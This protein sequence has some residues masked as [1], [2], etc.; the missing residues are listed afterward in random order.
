MSESNVCTL[1]PL[2]N[3]MG[4]RLA[5]S[6]IC[7]ILV[8]A[9]QVMGAGWTVGI[10]HPAGQTESQ[11]SAISGR[12][13]GYVAGPTNGGND[14]AAIF[15]SG[16]WTDL[17]PS[18]TTYSRA[19]GVSGDQVVGEVLPQ[20]GD[21]GVHAALWDAN[22]GSLTDLHPVGKWYSQAFGTD[23]IQQV[24]TAGS[25][26][27]LWTGSA[28]SIVYLTDTSIGSPTSV[29]YGVSGGRQVGSIWN[30]GTYRASLWSGSASS[31]VDLHP[32]GAASSDALA[33]SG[34]QQVG[35]SRTFAHDHAC[36]WRGSADSWTDLHPSG[37]YQSQASAVFGGRQAGWVQMEDYSLH[38]SIWAGSAG[39]WLDL[40]SYLPST[41]YESFAT[42][43]SV[44]GNDIWVAG[45]AT[46][47][48]TNKYEAVVWHQVVPEPSSLIA[49]AG[50]L[51]VLGFLRRR[52]R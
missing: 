51:G 19:S 44:Q 3:R 10:L 18:W 46:N 38:A 49:L 30:D 40:H 22:T 2:E 11:A 50:G 12:T 52:L 33:I 47:E 34:D 13:V 7:L 24:G 39:S 6:V 27:C 43:V 20:S 45:C 31:L 37:A 14:H 8:S 16:G 4:R 35:Y 17:G 32:A 42:G 9:S 41:Y 23:G 5:L 25:R 21:G 48:G 26:A 1:L 36:L 29:A 28:A 15:T